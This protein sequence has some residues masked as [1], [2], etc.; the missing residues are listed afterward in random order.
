L[1]VPYRINPELREELQKLSLMSYDDKPKLPK[2]PLGPMK[3][4]E[5]EDLLKVIE[6]AE[7]TRPLSNSRPRKTVRDVKF[8]LDS[9]AFGLAPKLRQCGFFTLPE[10]NR[11]KLVEICKENKRYIAISCGKAYRQLRLQIGDQAFDAPCS[12]QFSQN[13]L[14]EIVIRDLNLVVTPDDILSRCAKCNSDC[15]VHVPA[16][17]IKVLFLLKM[18]RKQIGEFKMDDARVAVEEL[19]SAHADR[20]CEVLITDTG[21]AVG[22]VDGQLDLING[23]VLA[24]DRD[25]PVSA[26]CDYDLNLV[27]DR[28]GLVFNVCGDCGKIFYE[29]SH[30][31]RIGVAQLATE[32]EP[33]TSRVF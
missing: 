32:D 13:Q 30:R 22:C 8:V 7:Q 19:R 33:T 6:R 15:L 26:K 3:R 4:G 18:I 16:P 12:S 21:I 5:E 29:G 17:A 25:M 24:N 20:K 9:M 10:E 14:L 27:Y 11:K 1:P 23:L 2:T 28:E 31:S